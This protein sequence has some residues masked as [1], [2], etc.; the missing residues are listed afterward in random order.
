MKTETW[1][2]VYNFQILLTVKRLRKEAILDAKSRTVS[3][4]LPDWKRI[5]QV[6]KVTI[7]EQGDE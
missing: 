3:I 5:Y 2:G 6:K 4:G 1:W 7:Q